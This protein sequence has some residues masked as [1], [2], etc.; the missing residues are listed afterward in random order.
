[1]ATASNQVGQPAGEDELFAQFP[2]VIYDKNP[3]EFVACE[4]R[5]PPV[6]K[7]ELDLP[8]AFQEAVRGQFPLFKETVPLNL[9]PPEVMKLFPNIANQSRSYEFS[10]GDG[11]WTAVLSR[12]ALTVVCKHY[13]RW[14]DFRL[15]LELPFKALMDAYSPEFFTRI[16]LRYRDVISRE[17]LGLQGTPWGELLEPAMV[18][19]FR[20]PLASLV[21]GSWHQ[22]MYRLSQ[23][24][25]QILLQHG[26]QTLVPNGEPSYI[27]D[28]DF[29]TEKRKEATDVFEL[30][31]FF[32]KHAWS[33]FRSCIAEKLHNA[34]DPKPV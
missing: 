32:N 13:T 19:E 9:L 26:L 11:I 2:K 5:F 23:E 3:L 27:F 12:G 1:M 17:R 6:L 15:R 21:I 24:D 4:F 33:V 14:N 25:A 31:K 20:A 8:V 7:I 16:G 34:M 22:V 18:G 30:L 28:T 29:F 10:S